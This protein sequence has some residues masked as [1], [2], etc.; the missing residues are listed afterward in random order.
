M[1]EQ[2]G[3]GTGT[4][5]ETS[6]SDLKELQQPNLYKIILLNDP[7][8]PGS[9]VASVLT[10]CYDKDTKTSMEIMQTAHDKGSCIVGIYSYEVGKT[11]L[12]KS[13]HMIKEAGYTLEFRMEKE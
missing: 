6:S 1:Q 10:E 8:T 4:E 11:R 13:Y 9:F 7:K 2:I 5:R 12:D 3:P